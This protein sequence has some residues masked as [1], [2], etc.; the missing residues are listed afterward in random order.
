MIALEAVSEGY[1]GQELLRGCSWRVGRGERIGLVGP[2][3]A[4][5]TTLFNVICGLQPPTTGSVRLG[6]RWL[7]ATAVGCSVKSLFQGALCQRSQ[8][9]CKVALL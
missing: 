7:G 9:N 3:G 8:K 1:G 5:K 6:A 2:N 4:G